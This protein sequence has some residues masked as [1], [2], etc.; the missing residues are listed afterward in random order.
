VLAGFVKGAIGMGLPTVAIG[1]LSTVMPPAQA[2]VLLVIP[3]L[4][5]NVW[6]LAAGKNLAPLLRRLW[7]LLAASA[8]VTFVSAGLMAKS[9]HQ[10]TFALGIA[11]I[12]YAAI[13]IAKVQIA[14]PARAEPWLSPAIGACTGLV[15]AAT[16]VMALPAVIYFQGIGLDKEDLIQA[17]GLS[18]TV[19]IVALGG[20]LLREGV[21]QGASVLA[22]LLALA[23]AA[24][25]MVAGQWLRLRIRPDI[26]RFCF[27][28][29]LLALGVDLVLRAVV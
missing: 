13:G 3:T 9:S 27:F 28:L 10:A 29:G 21:F 11:L 14:I 19:S 15:T 22:S 1:L 26:F 2:A 24:I 8:L 5:T 23:P 17:L 16:G 4:V 12:V 7:P 25:G 20:G 18:F 6:Q